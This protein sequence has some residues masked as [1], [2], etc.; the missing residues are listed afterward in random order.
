MVPDS[1]LGSHVVASALP[2]VG[3]KFHCGALVGGLVPC[4][5]GGSPG[6][7]LGLDFLPCGTGM[8]VAISLP[9]VS[10]GNAFSDRFRASD[11]F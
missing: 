11:D 2:S 4:A 5:Y 1:F 9:L 6:P 3:D 10:H 7:S 8:F